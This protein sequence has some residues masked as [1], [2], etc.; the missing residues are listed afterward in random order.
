MAAFAGGASLAITMALTAAIL[1][2]DF[3]HKPWSG[4]V[5][6]MALCRVFLYLMAASAVPEGHWRQNAV[7]LISAVVLGGY[8]VGLTWV[9]RM[10]GGKR[11]ASPVATLLAKILL[12]APGIAAAALLFSDGRLRRVAILG[13][14]TPL[15]PLILVFIFAAWV[16]HA[17]RVMRRG[18]PAIGQA[19]GLLLAGIP[20]V[21]ALAVSHASVLAALVFVVLAPLLRY[22]Q[23][24]V[25][26]T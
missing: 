13:D 5:V 25:A 6:V 22:W 18:G 19:V 2:Y 14:L 1:F 24:W 9:A 21:D 15:A 26:A 23:R 11:A 8:I 16:T 4:A 10:E 12:Y 20:L 7:L 17:A 3:Y